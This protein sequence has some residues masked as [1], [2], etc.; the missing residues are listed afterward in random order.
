MQLDVFK[1]T[2]ADAVAAFDWLPDGVGAA[3][4]V[5]VAALL[6][7]VL[8][9]VLFK[10]I[11]RAFAIRYPSLRPLLTEIAGPTRLA[12]ILLALTLA[13]PMA[14]LD[15]QWSAIITH[16]LEVALIVLIGWIVL[17]VISMAS[18]V[19]LRR[20]KLD[21]EDN[22][23]ARKHVTQVRVLNG[24]LS[25]LI[26][27]VTLAVALMTF[28]QVRE[29]GVGLFASAG[30]AGIIAGLAARPVLSNL[31]AGV[32]LAMTQ[33]IR[34]EDA[35]VVENEWGWIEEITSTFV[36][37]R[38]WDLRRMI[39]PLA[40]FME[41]PFQNWTREASAILGSVLLYLDYRAPIDRIRAKAE[42][43]AAANKLW[44]RKV[45]N[46][47]VTDTKERVIEVRVLVS[48]ANASAAFDLRCELRE[49]LIAF[50]R[51]EHPESLPRSRIESV[52]LQV[53]SRREFEPKT[54]RPAAGTH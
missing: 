26:I 39:V 19:Y 13:L 44:D 36:V 41:K 10:A 37:V 25:T 29:I 31:I 15:P 34:L 28:D 46:T 30:I 16:T 18:R 47:R 5:A 6:A 21:A 43:L 8:H 4:I 42:E 11:R 17:V 33:P 9:G 51:S 1:N 27:T 54:P 48:A 32:Q 52:D 2:W 3:L 23:L 20:F 22:L 14:R 24:V 35:V 50:L 40:Y 45:I 38:L 53:G 12:F 7:L 49:K